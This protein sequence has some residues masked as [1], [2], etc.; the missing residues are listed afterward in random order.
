[1]NVI[2]D[3]SRA[4]SVQLF[5]REKCAAWLPSCLPISMAV[6]PAFGS[7]SSSASRRATSLAAS[8][9]AIASGVASCIFSASLSLHFRKFDFGQ[10]SKIKNKQEH[11]YACISLLRQ[12]LGLVQISSASS[13][14]ETRARGIDAVDLIVEIEQI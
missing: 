13:V 14:R 2:I 6:L 8:A 9:A 1:M 11:L 12:T 4:K 5:A 10:I 7:Q 3:H